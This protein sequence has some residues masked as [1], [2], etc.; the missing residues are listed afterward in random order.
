MVKV[1]ISVRFLPAQPHCL[2]FGGFEIQMIQTLQAVKP[3][4]IDAK[5]LNPWSKSKNFDIA[6]IWGFDISQFRNIFFLKKAKKG[7]VVTALLDYSWSLKKKLKFLISSYMSITRY[8][9]R[10]AKLIDA[11]VV[12]NDIQR[13]IAIH[14]YK[15]EADK[16][17]VI[18]NIVHRNFY[19]SAIQ[20]NDI[21]YTNSYVITVG[22]ICPRKNQLNLARACIKAGVNLIIIG[23]VLD[24]E[25]A[26]GHK[27]S[28]VV[29]N[30]SSVKWVKALPPAST[31]LIEYIK[32]AS[33]FALPSLNETQPIS[34]LEA[35]VLRKPLLLS[36]LPF[37]KQKFF[38]NAC[39]VDP[40]NVD[41]IARAVVKI[42]SN[43][44]LYIPDYSVLQECTESSV[45]KAYAKV[46]EIVYEKVIS[47]G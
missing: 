40:Y 14:Y 24:G 11:F 31:E 42:I 4:G 6:H 20:D 25:E 33:V 41:N 19:L 8:Y 35:A 15:I 37:A 16:V 18:P 28:E 26:Y 1:M 17:F 46:Y 43:P 44:K 45:G 47:R 30:N 5:P 29:R 3:Y 21:T 32:R 34:A 7:V 38:K 22:N 13:D 2:S 39:L 36:D 10:M 23:N 12:L 27:L 9:L